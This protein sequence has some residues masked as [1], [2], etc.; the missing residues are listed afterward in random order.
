MAK[1]REIYIIFILNFQ[2]SDTLLSKLFLR[3]NFFVINVYYL[4]QVA[5]LKV[6]YYLYQV[7]ELKVI[8]CLYQVAELK[9]I[10]CLYQV[11][12]LKVMYFLSR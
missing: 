10:Y 4:Y 5:E 12:E 1:K 9:V 3:P 6:I 8:Y 2:F 7:A 11:A